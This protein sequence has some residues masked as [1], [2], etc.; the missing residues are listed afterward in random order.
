M[1]LEMGQKA[2]TFFKGYISLLK[3]INEELTLQVDDT[4]IKAMGMDPSH[5]AM[6]DSKLKAPLFE[7]FSVPEGGSKVIIN[8]GDFDKFLDRIGKDEAVTIDYS[9]EKA[10]LFI[11][12]KASGRT[13]RFSLAVLEPLE[14]EIPEPKIFFK[15]S[16]RLL[17]QG[18]ERAIKDAGL[19]SEW[20]RIAIEGEMLKFNAQGDLG[21]ADN[22]YTKDS[23]E[24][25]EL[26]SEAD[27]SATYTL[28]YL[29]DMFGALKSVADVVTLELSTD[30][31]VKIEA[32][33][34][35]PNLEVTLYLAPMIGV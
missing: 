24:V 26:K 21:S 6:I 15:S 11:V 5:V 30:M 23:D 16:A 33:P 25:L 7:A 14:D 3:V 29:S 2:L 27:S 19:V 20:L 1:H 34:N 4:G 12:T 10:K 35:N 28:S 9:E 32:S 31:P 22:E 17:T 18:V 13:R 8:L